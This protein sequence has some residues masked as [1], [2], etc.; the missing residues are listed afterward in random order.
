M[1]HFSNQL[2]LE[3]LALLHGRAA[4]QAVAR[5]VARWLA[6]GPWAYALARLIGP[7][8]D[9][10]ILPVTALPPAWDEA[11]RRVS[12]PAPDA[13]LPP[14]QQVMGII[15]VTPDSFSDGGQHDRVETA[16][17]RIKALHA[18]GCEVVD[19][20]GESTRPGAP[21]VSV[22]A[23]W[24]RIG[25]VIRAVRACSALDGLNLSIDTRHAA[26][27]DRALMAGAT[28]INDVSALAH[29]PAA[30]A[31]VARH[32]CPVMLMHMRGTPETMRAH[33]AYG[34]VAVDVVRELGQRVDEAV[35]AGIARDRIMVDPGI[36]FAKTLEGNLTL[37]ARLP[38]LANLGCRVV[39]GTSRKRMIGELAHE[40]DAAARDPGTIAASLPGMV[41]AD[42]VLRV[43]NATA[44]I[45]AMRV[46]QGLDRQ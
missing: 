32:G 22:E 19:I 28:L 15:N 4:R 16:L 37:L 10:T 41:F 12:A 6:G 8:Q 23:E 38:L 3:P 2:L 24:A 13:G 14:G 35:A 17:A 27:M 20:G 7:G 25:P 43:H 9:D 1:S 29:D 39:L 11:A 5:G 34:D 21:A 36:G 40:P 30:R 42:V 31:V 44:M 18:A 26:V 33:T 46:Q 45:Q